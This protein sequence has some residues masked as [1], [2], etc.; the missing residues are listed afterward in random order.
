MIAAFATVVISFFPSLSYGK[1]LI[2]SV[3]NEGVLNAAMGVFS[4]VFSRSEAVACLL[5]TFL[6][7][8]SLALHAS[9]SKNFPDLLMTEVET[10][11]LDPL[12]L[13]CKHKKWTRLCQF[14]EMK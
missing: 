8:K 6:L 5:M 7:Y 14:R 2:S 9:V 4:G 12:T 10:S 13:V 1:V 11:G 3:L